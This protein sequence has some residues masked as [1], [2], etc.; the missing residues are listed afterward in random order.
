MDN[1]IEKYYLEQA[2]TGISGYQ[3]HRYSL[4]PQKGSGIWSSIMKFLYPA[5]KYLGKQAL[6]TGINIAD[7][8]INNNDDIKTSVRKRL[9]ETKSKVLSDTLNKV[10]NMNNQ[11]GKGIKRKKKAK[12]TIVRKKRKTAHKNK[13]IK[14]KRKTTKTLKTKRRRKSALPET[15]I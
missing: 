6:N 8:V 2:G 13:G 10:K 12:T 9:K 15:F 5:A 1:K 14:R 4:K 7:D 3:G 11:M